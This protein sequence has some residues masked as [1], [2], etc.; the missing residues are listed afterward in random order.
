MTDLQELKAAGY[1]CIIIAVGALKGKANLE[2][3]KALGLE[4]DESG[5]DVL[6]PN[7][8]VAGD[9]INGTSSVVLA[10]SSASKAVDAIL[11]LEPRAVIS[12]GSAAEDAAAKKGI[13]VHSADVK[14]EAER[15]LE[16]GLVCESCADVCP[17]RANVAVK[18][19]GRKM[20]QIIHLD[21]MCNE[22]GNC[23][24]FCPYD[25]SP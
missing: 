20:A 1:D 17:N 13:I 23:T 4:F 25:S 24:A 7:V 16:C 11:R 18:V 10:I 8:Y 21:Y 14:N 22:C 3:L 9:C 2:Y 15:C 5:T 12:T 19:P 6:E